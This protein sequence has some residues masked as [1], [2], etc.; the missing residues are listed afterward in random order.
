MIKKLHN[1]EFHA[2]FS[3][4]SDFKANQSELTSVI[5]N[6]FIDLIGLSLDGE[7]VRRKILTTEDKTLQKTTDERAYFQLK[8]TPRSQGLSDENLC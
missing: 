8:S 3:S 4:T 1:E 2:L 7:S 5:I 6:T